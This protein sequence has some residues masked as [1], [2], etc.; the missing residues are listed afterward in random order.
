MRRWISSSFAHYRPIITAQ[1]L[2]LSIGFFCIIYLILSSFS[3]ISN[4]SVIPKPLIQPTQVNALAKISAKFQKQRKPYAFGYYEKS[5]V[6]NRIRKKDGVR[7]TN[8]NTTLQDHVVNI[9]GRK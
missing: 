8:V 4:G 3:Q 1:L 6:C 9:L 5:F 7:D 2:S